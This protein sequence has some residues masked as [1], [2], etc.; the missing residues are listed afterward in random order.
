MALTF[1]G[2]IALETGT[3][4]EGTLKLNLW[5]HIR[6]SV[7]CGTWGVLSQAALGPTWCEVCFLAPTLSRGEMSPKCLHKLLT[8]PAVRITST[9]EEYVMLSCQPAVVPVWYLLSKQ[10]HGSFV[11]LNPRKPNHFHSNK[12]VKNVLK[13]LQ[14]FYSLNPN[15]F[16]FLPFLV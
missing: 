15:S 4:L 7:S 2:V 16:L 3:S 8:W 10:A 9:D 6:D 12:T 11:S 5:S 13:R 14:M 1:L